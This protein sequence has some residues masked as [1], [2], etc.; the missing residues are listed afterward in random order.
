[1]RYPP[2]LLYNNG[3]LSFGCPE[4]GV[5]VKGTGMEG[6]KL[7]SA[8]QK[9]NGIGKG[10]RFRFRNGGCV[11]FCTELVYDITWYQLR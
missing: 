3:E 9:E 11:Y 6:I 5:G 8:E 4:G 7:E 1:M 10:K 2:K